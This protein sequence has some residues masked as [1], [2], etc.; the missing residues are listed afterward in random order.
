MITENAE[1]MLKNLYSEAKSGC[2]MGITVW[3]DRTK[4]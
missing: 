3:G 4:S 1:K 2:L